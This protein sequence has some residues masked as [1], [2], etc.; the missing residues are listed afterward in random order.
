VKKDTCEVAAC[1]NKPEDDERN[2]VITT[3]RDGG[4]TPMLM[5]DSCWH[6]Y[7]IGV[8]EGKREVRQG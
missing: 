6:A 8:H 3:D 5:C 1:M 4:G 2:T 7:K